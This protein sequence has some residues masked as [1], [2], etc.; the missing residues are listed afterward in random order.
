MIFWDDPHRPQFGSRITINN[1][2]VGL[3][4]LTDCMV[5]KEINLLTFKIFKCLVSK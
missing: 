3:Q 4:S 1:F 5:G 2:G